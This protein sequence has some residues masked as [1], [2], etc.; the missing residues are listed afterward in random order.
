M[1][2]RKNAERK[3]NSKKMPDGDIL[4]GRKVK[5]RK[6]GKERILTPI[7]F[8][9]LKDASVRNSVEHK[10]RGQTHSRIS[11]DNDRHSND[12]NGLE[13]GY[14]LA[15]VCK[16]MGRPGKPYPRQRQAST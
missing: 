3:K 16:I 14:S 8:H 12:K 13:S 6:V 5:K 15:E 10:S 11:H 2:K 9:M 7:L 4:F 1:E